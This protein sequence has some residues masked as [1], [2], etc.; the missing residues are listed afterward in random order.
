MKIYKNKEMFGERKEI[1]MIKVL[2]KG[3]FGSRRDTIFKFK[4]IK[5]N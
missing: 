2:R 5:I 3:T 1:F 4:M